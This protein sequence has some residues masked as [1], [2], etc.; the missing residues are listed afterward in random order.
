M[1]VPSSP[2]PAG[3]QVDPIGEHLSPPDSQLTQCQ[4]REV[5]QA[6][7]S[8]VPRAEHAAIRTPALN[9]IPPPTFLANVCFVWR[10]PSPGRCQWDVSFLCVRSDKMALMHMQI[11]LLEKEVCG[12]THIWLEVLYCENTEE[13]YALILP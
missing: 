11:R 8:V 6:V 10:Y 3:V 4:R 12:N 5:S 7:Q 1:Q 2:T 9:S 13:A